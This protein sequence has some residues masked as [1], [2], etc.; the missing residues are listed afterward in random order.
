MSIG[1]VVRLPASTTGM[2]AC[3]SICAVCGVC[4]TPVR[5]S[6][7]TRRDRNACTSVCSSRA[8]K[9]L[10]PRS[11]WKPL[12]AS[13]SVSPWMISAISELVSTGTIAPTSRDRCDASALA[14]RSGV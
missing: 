9:P 11:I 1:S 4:V 13:A 7:S 8:E 12:T 14:V 10:T 6:P 3:C 5:N 2:P